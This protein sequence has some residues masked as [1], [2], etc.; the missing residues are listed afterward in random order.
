MRMLS[1]R[2][3]R[4]QFFYYNIYHCTCCKTQQIRHGRN[5]YCYCQDRQQARQRFD[6][7]GKHTVYE[8]PALALACCI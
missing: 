8:C 3:F 7:S 1:L 4:D 5:Y 2:H 6:S